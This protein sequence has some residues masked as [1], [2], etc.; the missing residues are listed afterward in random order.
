MQIYPRSQNERKRVDASAASRR[1]IILIAS[2]MARKKRRGVAPINDEL[3]WKTRRMN[4]RRFIK[5]RR[6]NQS[7]FARFGADTRIPVENERRPVRFIYRVEIAIEKVAVKRGN[8]HCRR[9][10]VSIRICDL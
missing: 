6:R 7:S 4:R 10:H 1:S 5:V 9:F 8:K 3:K 2:K